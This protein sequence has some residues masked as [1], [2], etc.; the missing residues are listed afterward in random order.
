M[1]DSNWERV[2]LVEAPNAESGKNIGIVILDNIVSHPSISHLENRVKR[3]RVAHDYSITCSN[4]TEEP[5]KI[6][7]KEHKKHGL[8]ILNLLSHKPFDLNE[9]YYVGL[10]S[11]STFIFLPTS[12][13]P[14]K[15][16]LGLEWILDQDWNIR[17]LL[18]LRVPEAEGWMSPNADHPHFQALAPALTKDI[19]IVSAGG[20]SK[21]HNNLHPIE[22]FTISGFNDHG[23]HQV[24]NYEQHPSVPFGMNSE[25]YYRPDLLAPYTYLPL[26]SL[27]GRKKLDY[28]G[29]TCGSA[30]LIAG[31]SAY[32]FSTIAGLSPND[33]R[34]AFIRAGVIDNK[35]EAPIV[36]GSKTLKLLRKGF[37]A[38]D[39][40]VT[41]T[42]IKVTD[43]F[44]DID[45]KS[46]IKRA[47]ALTVLIQRARLSRDEIWEY[48]DDD[49]AEVKKVA[50]TGLEAPE[51]GI[52]RELFWSYTFKESS[53]F[54]VREV[55]AYALLKTSVKA[56]I[57][58][59][60]KLIKVNPSIDL[61]ICLSFFL[62]EHYQ[63]FPEMEITPDPASIHP[64]VTSIIDWYNDYVL[65]E[66]KDL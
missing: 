20:N 24:E 61:L 63:S 26:P 38:S 53:Q 14:E 37:K 64:L 10:A 25:G 19:L 13:E 55:W 65:N 42:L 11:A 12:S 1:I 16:K 45:S 39:G 52:E 46:A 28:F 9:K 66:A 30:T 50:I 21:A 51:N 43:P 41:D 35:F 56:E 6:N 57:S 34:S 60:I 48:V 49:S 40:L 4:V 5:F 27:L 62:K 32:Y 7:L 23:L 44:V 33:I 3:V 18:N 15:T 2:G 17:I 29:G 59:W 54:G 8:M 36:N 31:L 22:Y 47:L 58:N